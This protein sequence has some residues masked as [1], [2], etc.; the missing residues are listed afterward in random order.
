MLYQVA[1]GLWGLSILGLQD[2]I[3]PQ[4]LQRI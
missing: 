4:M 2:P 3:F 1:A